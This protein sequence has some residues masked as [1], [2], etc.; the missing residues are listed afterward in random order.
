MP[1]PESLCGD[2]TE[3]CYVLSVASGP[4]ELD[5]GSGPNGGKSRDELCSRCEAGEGCNVYADPDK[6]AGC[7]T[8][9]C[10]WL[11]EGLSADLRPDRAGV[12]MRRD[13]ATEGL[14][15][16]A[17]PEREGDWRV[18]AMRELIL[19]CEGPVFIHCGEEHFAVNGE[20]KAVLRAARDEVGQVRSSAL[21]ALAALET[22]PVAS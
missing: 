6:P 19:E 16:Y 15:G 11:R 22:P 9:R 5:L 2:C 3:C 8:Y 12:V 18:G 1:A 21:A 14:L 20:A 10:L 7:G 17:R 4:D 13:E